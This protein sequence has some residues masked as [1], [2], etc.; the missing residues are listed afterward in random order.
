MATA[1]FIWDFSLQHK[2]ITTEY[3]GSIYIEGLASDYLPDRDDEYV[4]RNALR[5]GLAQY[6]ATNPIVLFMHKWEKAVG[7]VVAARIDDEGLH[8][9]ARLDAATD[10]SSWQADI[11]NKVKSG[12]LKTFSI[13]GRF[14]KDGPRI[15][16]VDLMEISIAT[17][18]I[19]ARSLFRVV[20][21]K[22]FSDGDPLELGELRQRINRAAK[23]VEDLRLDQTSLL[24]AS[25]AAEV[26]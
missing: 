9:K 21:G 14:H 17:V 1:P 15:H 7:R 20:A 18:P 12:T 10:P 3:D 6:M 5:E 16:K 26:R 2:A 25:I 11:I 19:N 23:A 24:A 8:V 4:D 22:A 13:G